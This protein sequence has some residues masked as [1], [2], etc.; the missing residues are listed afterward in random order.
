MR[1]G[2]FKDLFAGVLSC[3]TKTLGEP[4]LYL[5]ASGGSFELYGV[6][7][8]KFLGI[9]P[10]T[11]ERIS[12]SDPHLGVKLSQFEVEPRQGDQVEIEG[13]RYFV[14]EVQ[15]D[16]QGGAEIMLIREQNR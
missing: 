11:E 4:F 8:E 7:D 10:D 6:F 9:D 5:P 3:T 15:R 16:G 13:Q 1:K 14:K 2:S 12:S